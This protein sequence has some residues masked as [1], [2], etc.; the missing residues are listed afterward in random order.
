MIKLLLENYNIEILEQPIKIYYFSPKNKK[1]LLGHIIPIL[2][3]DTFFN[4]C[5]SNEEFSLFIS[6]NIDLSNINNLVAD[7]QEYNVI[8]INYSYHQINDVGVVHEISKIFNSLNIPILYINSFNNNF[9]LIPKNN[10][11][12][13]EKYINSPISNLQF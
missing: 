7:H 13:I 3:D 4:I 9:I 1:E 8:Q 11:I 12:E 2:Y 5:Q 6:S 10:I